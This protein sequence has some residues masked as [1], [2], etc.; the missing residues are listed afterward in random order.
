[1]IVIVNVCQIVVRLVRLR[2]STVDDDDINAPNL[3]YAHLNLNY[4]FLESFHCV[5]CV[6]S[7]DKFLD[8]RSLIV[9]CDPEDLVSKF[10]HLSVK[11]LKNVLDGHHVLVSKHV[12][13]K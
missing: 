1:M 12:K 7:S 9:K 10:A 5:D 2:D 11:Q 4:V 3:S 8:N 6:L 13:K